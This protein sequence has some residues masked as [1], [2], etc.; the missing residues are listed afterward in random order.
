MWIVLLINF[1]ATSTVYIGAK[2]SLLTSIS[3]LSFEDDRS[4]EVES[5]DLTLGQVLVLPFSSSVVLLLLF[6]YFQYIQYFLLALLV[7]VSASALNALLFLLLQSVYKERTNKLACRCISI[8]VTLGLVLYWIATGDLIIHNILGCA[9][10]IT[11]ISTLKFPSLKIAVVC[12]VLLTVYDIFWVFFSEY[13]FRENVMIDVAQKVA[14][15]PVHTVGKYLKNDYVTSLVKSKIE[16]PLKLIFKNFSTGKMMILGLGDI[17]LPGALVALALRCDESITREQSGGDH[18]SAVAT[19]TCDLEST[20][21]SDKYSYG[22]KLSLSINESY[23]NKK[24]VDARDSSYSS[25]SIHSTPVVPSRLFDCAVLGYTS[26]LFVAFAASIM[27]GHGQPALI[28]LV[29]GVLLPIVGRAW[30]VGKL[31]HVWHGPEK[32]Q[33]SS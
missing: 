10:C 17:A 16:L 6:F 12:L 33:E 8:V 26:G 32:I 29:P 24:V 23:Y 19:K 21:S 30:F 18:D 11:F 13:F 5:V 25:S 20:E 31:R 9:L 1:V 3:S 2:L 28:Y 14:A 7:F 15:N 22:E 4:Q 27:S